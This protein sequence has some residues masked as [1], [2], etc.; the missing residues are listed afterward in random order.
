MWQQIKNNK[1]NSIILIT[2]MFFLL[3]SIGTAFGGM[4][5]VFAEDT[6]NLLLFI[7]IGMI[8]SAVIWLC[9]LLSALKNGKKSILSTVNAYKLP[10]HAH[11]VLENVVEEM[12]IAAGLPKTPEIYVIDTEMPNAF[13]TGLSPE[14]SAVAVTTGLLTKLNRDELQ[15]VI[16]HEIAHIVNRDTMYMLLAGVMIGSIVIMC[17]FG[18]RTF[19]R[20][21]C[22]RRSSKN[23]NGGGDIVIL[24]ICVIAMVI[25]PIVAELLYFL[26]SQ[27]REYLADACAVQFTR[28]PAGLAS[29]L[30][31]ISGSS[32]K[33]IECNIV[34]DYGNTE[35][36]KYNKI[37]YSMFTVNP[38]N[39]QLQTSMFNSC[40]S[41]HPPTQK[42]IDVLLKMNGADYKSYNEAFAKVSGSNSRTIL[43]SQDLKD[44]KRL[45]I[46][47]PLKEAVS[48]TAAMSAIQINDNNTTESIPAIKPQKIT[49]KT[50]TEDTIWHSQEYIFEQLTRKREAEDAIWHSQEYIFKQCECG[51]KLKFPKDYEGQEIACPH[52][53]RIIKVSKNS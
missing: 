2:A 31:K 30:A 34:D 47:T 48:N 43:D 42:R 3:L 46:R 27:R 50:E 13:A 5:A 28:Y 29:A 17:E 38:K 8:T 32:I 52:C 37:I 26:I 45:K 39:T 40:F 51:T 49:P 1:R 18:L 22:S 44:S 25:A 9:L 20:S 24:L 36:I 21:S 11:L 12:S 10:P 19:S 16:A 53:K 23:S 14:N 15:G 41:T 33:D 4:F 6:E 7:K 35:G